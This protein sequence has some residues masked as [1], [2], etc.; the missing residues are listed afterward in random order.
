MRCGCSIDQCNLRVT[1]NRRNDSINASELEA[2]ICRVGVVDL[3]GNGVS[4]KILRSCQC[5]CA[6][7]MDLMLNCSSVRKETRRQLTCSTCHPLAVRPGLGLE[8]QYQS[9][10]AGN[11]ELAN[12]S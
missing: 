8:G 9:L 10:D 4:N 5:P 7:N 6:D 1:A 3:G 12:P 11:G 2:E